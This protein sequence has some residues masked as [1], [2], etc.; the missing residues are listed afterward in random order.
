MNNSTENSA[1]GQPK[2]PPPNLKQILALREKWLK[3]KV[4]DDNNNDKGH[5]MIAR[6]TLMHS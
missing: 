5:R 2:D 1:N 3:K 6:V 4:Q